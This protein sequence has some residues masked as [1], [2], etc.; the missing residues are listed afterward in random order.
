MHPFTNNEEQQFICKKNYIKLKYLLAEGYCYAVDDM[1][2]FE[3][4]VKWIKL[5]ENDKSFE[6]KCKSFR[7]I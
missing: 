4:N 2:A 5:W 1:S 6:N 7:C 3:M